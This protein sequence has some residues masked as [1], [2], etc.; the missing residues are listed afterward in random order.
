MIGGFSKNQLNPNNN[1]SPQ[2][3]GFLGGGGHFDNSN[4]IPFGT[5]TH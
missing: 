2:N 5:A 4:M 3:Y 1:Y